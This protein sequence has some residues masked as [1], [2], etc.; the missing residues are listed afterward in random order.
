MAMTAA[1]FFSDAVFLF[2][3]FVMFSFFIS[4]FCVDQLVVA[5]C[6]SLLDNAPICVDVCAI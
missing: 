1:L 2:F 5:V 6:I 4:I 3:V